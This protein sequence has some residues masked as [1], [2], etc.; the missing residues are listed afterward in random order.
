M[1]NKYSKISID[2]NLNNHYLEYNKMLAY[3]C[4]TNIRGLKIPNDEMIENMKSFTKDDLLNI[5]SIYNEYMKIMITLL[6]T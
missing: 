1:W 2:P 6:E 3:K 5:I 4:S